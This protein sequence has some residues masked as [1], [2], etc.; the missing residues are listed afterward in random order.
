MGKDVW[1]DLYPNSG[2]DLLPFILSY[3]RDSSIVLENQT[4]PESSWG[5]W[6]DNEIVISHE[7]VMAYL[8]LE[9]R[10]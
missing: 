4:P 10:S 2:I 3:I 1:D 8:D 6:H 5:S 9:V 7:L